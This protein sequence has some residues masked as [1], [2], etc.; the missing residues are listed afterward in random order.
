MP[1]SQNTARPPRRRLAAAALAT[2]AAIMLVGCISTPALKPEQA[3][4]EVGFASSEVTIPILLV[5]GSQGSIGEERIRVTPDAGGALSIDISEDEVGG[6]GETFHAAA[7]NAVVVATFLS[8]VDIGHNYRFELRG[9]IDG[10]SAGGITTVALLSLI[11]GTTIAPGTAMTGTIT[12]TG[13]IGPVGGVPEKIAAVIEDGSYE[14]VLIPLGSRNSVDS[15]GQQV[16]VVRLGADAGLEVI[17]VGDVAEAYQHLTGEALPSPNSVAIP[18]ISEPGYSRLELA[19]QRQLTEFDGIE[20]HYLSLSESILSVGW[21]SYLE[22]ASSAEEARRLLDQGLPGGAFV[23]ALTANL[24]IKALDGAYSTADDTFARGIDVLNLAFSA[25]D[26]TERVF[27]D[28]LDQ[29]D[30][31]KVTTLADAEAL[32]TAYGN[33]FDAYTLYIYGRDGIDDVL[34]YAEQG[35]YSSLDEVVYASL[36][37]LLYL[38]FS[39]AQVHAAEAIFEVGR[40]LEAPKLA[41]DADVAAIASFLRRAAEANLE[42]FDAGVLSTLAEGA[43]ISDAVARERL[44]DRDLGVAMAYTGRDAFYAIDAYLGADNPNS[45]YAAMGYGWMNF[46]R[47]ASLVEKYSTNGVVDPQTFDLVGASSASLLTHS[48]DYSRGQLARSIESLE[49]HEYSPVLIVGAFEAAGLKR[50]RADAEKFEALQEYTGS[51]AMTRVLAYLGGFAT[52][53]YRS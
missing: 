48:L 18:R 27:T 31:Y 36:P 9:R 44:G 8:G 33:A 22:A 14:K 30:T 43:G 45:P 52:E 34:A 37:P 23:E 42:T 6:F 2:A 26:T 1:A 13:T 5:G 12:P 53:G 7:W 11:H 15:F 47:N 20:S 50:E 4:A 21:E 51:F 28:F 39:E 19:A 25:A 35:G 3:A 38:E 49:S 16:D 40:G 32:I 46:A 17:E 41:D 10:P 24:L 29:L